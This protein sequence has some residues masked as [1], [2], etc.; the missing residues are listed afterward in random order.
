M[1]GTVTSE[2]GSAPSFA[3][4]SL[5]VHLARGAAGLGAIAASFALGPVIGW[6]SLLFLPAGLVALR[7]CP[8]CWTIGLIQTISRGRLERECTDGQCRLARAPA[9]SAEKGN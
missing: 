1:S 8:T 6:G 9:C 4:K 3:S 2:P 5:A 7:G